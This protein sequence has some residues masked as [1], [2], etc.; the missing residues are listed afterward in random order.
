MKAMQ[1]VILG[2]GLMMVLGIGVVSASAVVNNENP[3]DYVASI[4]VPDN[5]D[6]AQ[7]MSEAQE[8]AQLAPLAKITAEEAKTIAVG[9]V[10]GEIA[11][12]ELENE[13]GN[14]VY[15]VEIAQNN[16]ELDVK[17]DAGNGN[18]LK[19]DDGADAEKESELTKKEDG[20]AED[21]IDHQFEGEEEQ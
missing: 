2:L 1:K 8:S 11:K 20:F 10:D 5:A 6:G 9:T 15:S 16:K 12:V 18:V 14:L 13:N 4:T 17:I 7:E 3:L 19:I 21:G